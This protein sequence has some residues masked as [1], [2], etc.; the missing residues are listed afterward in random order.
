[1]HY[2]RDRLSFP[3]YPAGAASM[4]S[5]L[6]TLIAEKV[7]EPFGL[8]FCTGEG[9]FFPDGTEESSGCVVTRSGR[10]FDFWTGW[11]A[12]HG[13]LSLERWQPLVSHDEWFDDTE[14]VD[15]VAEAQR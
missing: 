15:A 3:D 13:H 2:L 14:Y 12:T 1:M 9:R 5:S 6:C 8:F 11:D 7:G 4:T 10:H